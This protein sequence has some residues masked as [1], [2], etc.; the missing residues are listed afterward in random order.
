[1]YKK[2]GCQKSIS[3]PINKKKQD[4]KKYKL[5]AFYLQ[6]GRKKRMEGDIY[7]HPHH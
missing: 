3:L 5:V 1:M 2:I 7:T 6:I 4:A